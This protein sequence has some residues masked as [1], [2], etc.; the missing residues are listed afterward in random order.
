MSNKFFKF[1]RKLKN[2]KGNFFSVKNLAEVVKRISIRISSNKF[3]ELFHEIN[4]QNI[5]F[6]KFFKH[7]LFKFLQN[8]FKNS[9]CL[10]I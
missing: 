6:F 2:F 5:Q 9:E 10:I 4:F 8:F 7:K 3:G 1:Q